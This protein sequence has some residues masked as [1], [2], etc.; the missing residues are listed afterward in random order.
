MDATLAALRAPVDLDLKNTPLGDALLSLRKAGAGT[1]VPVLVN[2][3]ALQIVGASLDTPVSIRAQ[4]EPL[5]EPLARL[6]KPLGLTYAVIDGVLF[7]TYDT[8]QGKSSGKGPDKVNRTVLLKLEAPVRVRVKNV[9]LGDV[10]GFVMRATQ[11]PGE[12]G[13]SIRLDPEGLRR[14]RVTTATRVSVE[15]HDGEPLRSSLSRMLRSVNLAYHVADGLILVRES[16]VQLLDRSPQTRKIEAKLEQRIDL[17]FADAPLEDVLKFIKAATR[18][19]GD[20]GIPIYIDPVGL[21]E[22]EVTMTSRV[23]IVVRGETLKDGLRKVLRP[24]HLTYMV[25][26]GLLTVTSEWAEDAPFDA[27][28]GN[29]PP[30]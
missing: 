10:L 5:S 27:A 18:G 25:K 26:D 28:G 3:V 22:A 30:F 8:A 20:N 14:A 1:E 29:G 11:A 15:S 12:E 7:V 2:P 17:T 23:S 13:V 9:P 21:Q 24:L 16:R 19:T 4:A 6:L